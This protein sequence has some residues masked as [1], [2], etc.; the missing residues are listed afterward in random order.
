MTDNELMHYGVLGMKWGKR[1]AQPA[2][3]VQ[4]TRAAYKKANKEYSKAYDSAYG[5][6]S[7]HMVSQFAGKKAKAESDKRWADA[8]AKAKAANAAKSAYKA[9]KSKQKAK[10]ISDGKDLY[11]K[12]NKY[13]AKEGVGKAAVKNFLMGPAGKTTYDM[14]RSMNHSRASSF[15]RAMFDINVSQLAG[16]AA[17]TAVN[18]GAQRATGK[19]TSIF[20]TAANYGAQYGTDRAYRNSGKMASLQQ[21]RLLK[22]YQSRKR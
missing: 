13:A 14:A 3:D 4:R 19:Q 22:E 10:N 6:S 11:S 12:T 17:G 18:Y 9:A 20:G 7:R 16:V 15:A 2:N 5:Y 21:R 1:K 8:T